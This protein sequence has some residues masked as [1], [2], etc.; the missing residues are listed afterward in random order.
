M[1]DIVTDYVTSDGTNLKM[2][3]ETLLDACRGRNTSNLCVHGV[4]VVYHHAED[5][6]SHG[7]TGCQDIRS[8]GITA[9]PSL[10]KSRIMGIADI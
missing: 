9:A 7:G 3:K 8:F 10:S 2:T 6:T 4:Q 1:S 5:S